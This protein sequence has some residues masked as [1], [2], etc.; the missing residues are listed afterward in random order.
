MF[1]SVLNRLPADADFPGDDEPERIAEAF[2][3]WEALR[4]MS[5]AMSGGD[6]SANLA[7]CELAVAEARNAYGAIA[8]A[9]F[10]LGPKSGGDHIA[11][12]HEGLTSFRET[13]EL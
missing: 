6:I 7:A 11:E 13:A 5:G 10:R 9:G 4:A 8:A 1:P 12:I 3:A 2:Q